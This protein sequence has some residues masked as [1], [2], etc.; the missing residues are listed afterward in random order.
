MSSIVQCELSDRQ[1]KCVHCGAS[2]EQEKRRG[3]KRK[4]CSG[5]CNQAHQRLNNGTLPRGSIARVHTFECIQC[6]KTASKEYINGYDGQRAQLCSTA[7]RMARHKELRPDFHLKY[8]LKEGL[9]YQVTSNLCEDCGKRCRGVRCSSCSRVY[10]KPRICRDCGAGGLGKGKQ[11]CSL[12]REKSHQLS[13]ARAKEKARKSGVLAANRKARKLKQRGVTV[14]AVNATIVL[15]RDKWT[16]QICGIKT[17][18]R[19][20]GSYD[21]RAPEI[22]HIIPIAQ[23]GEHSYRNVQCACRRCNAS[24]SAMALGQMRLF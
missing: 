23:G 11:Q 18:K 5:K 1:D 15:N 20:R 6:G 16:C 19:L 12:C 22:D 8:R 2:L 3:R 14:E 10:L 9:K 4:F 17:P 7:C 13:K 24:K 21:D